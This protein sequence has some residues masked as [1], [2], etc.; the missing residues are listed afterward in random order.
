[1]PQF[2]ASRHLLRIGKGTKAEIDRWKEGSFLEAKTGRTIE[3][4]SLRAGADR[5]SLAS[6]CLKEVRR[7][8]K[9]GRGMYRFAVSRYYY[10]MYHAMRAVVYVAHGGDDFQEH[11]SLPGNA[12][13]DF[14]DRAIWSNALKN[15]RERRNAADYDPYPKSDSA[16]RSDAVSLEAQ[17]ADFLRKVK[18]YLQNKG[19]P[20]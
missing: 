6:A 17:A 3:Q 15:A 16:W 5:F 11:K 8:N 4:L 2:A 7:L 1:M 19:C 18:S 14:T 12:P 10:S 20:V 9:N 13:A